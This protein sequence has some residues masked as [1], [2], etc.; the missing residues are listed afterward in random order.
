ML[1]IIT[2][3]FME[4]DCSWTVL[5]NLNLFLG[6]EHQI[7]TKDSSASSRDQYIRYDIYIYGM[8][9]TIAS[10]DLTD[11]CHGRIIMHTE[12]Y[13]FTWFH[14]QKHMIWLSNIWLTRLSVHQ[15]VVDR[16]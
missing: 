4:F 13:P 10:Q 11:S 7:R 15:Y 8:P 12:V 6:L 2:A 14:M 5:N 1:R 9:Q 3:L 16:S